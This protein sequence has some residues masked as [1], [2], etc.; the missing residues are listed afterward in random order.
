IKLNGVAE[1]MKLHNP[2]DEKI[3]NA[4]RAFLSR[5]SNRFREA[6]Y[7]SALPLA[8]AGAGLVVF[9]FAG[10][11]QALLSH[12][13]GLSSIGL[14][15]PPIKFDDLIIAF[16]TQTSGKLVITVAGGFSSYKLIKWRVSFR[17]IKSIVDMFLR[18]NG[19]TT[20]AQASDTVADAS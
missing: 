19:Q 18:G 9:S 20:V 4:R 7:R 2:G 17:G 8:A 10:D 1:A 5:V 6:M 15:S 16:D 3:E 13:G 11:I 12:V 14:S